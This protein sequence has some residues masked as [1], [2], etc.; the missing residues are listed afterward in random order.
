LLPLIAG[1]V[2]KEQKFSV[3][4]S[5]APSAVSPAPQ[6]ADLLLVDASPDAATYA[7]V[8]RGSYR[9]AVTASA[10]VA[11]QFLHRQ[12]PAL[13]VTEL[14][15][16]S[17]DGVDICR[18]AKKLTLPPPVLVTT[19]NAER[20]PNA[21]VAGCDGVLLK[22]F[23]PNLLYAR[24]GRLLRTRSELLR[25]RARQQ[26]LKTAHLA[27]RSTELLGGTNRVWPHTH[28]PYC[29]HGG[30]TSF[31]FCSHRRS[32]YACLQCKKVWIAKRQE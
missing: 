11:K 14:E 32:W 16:P 8:L 6:V 20:V 9:V 26:S 5:F 25:V 17:A 7:A 31:E 30:V 21:L 19:S 22:P 1:A 13:V 18:E 10:E 4:T 2:R 15:L 28:C 24:I 23:A 27:D 29:N 3:T 12:S